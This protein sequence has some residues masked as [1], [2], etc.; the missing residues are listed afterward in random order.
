MIDL[1]GN[2]RRK[3]A[4]IE[5]ID[6]ALV[7]R[8]SYEPSRN[9]LG[10]SQLGE[11]CE[12]ALQYAYFHTPVEEDKEIDGQKQRIFDRGHM[13]EEYMLKIMRLA[14]FT[15][16]TKDLK[17]RTQFEF[18]LLEGRVKGHCDGVVVDGPSALNYPCL[19]ENKCLGDKYFKQLEKERLK[20]YSST[21]YGQV[22]IMAA[23]FELTENPSLFTA[24]NAND[25]N[26]YT[27]LVP[28]DGTE[29]QAI[30][31]KAVRIVKACD[32]GEQLSRITTDQSFWKCKWCSWYKRCWAT[33]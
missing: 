1:N 8:R 16:L 9:Y 4:I 7:K 29:A 2:T 24:L 31:D 33:V 21:Y 32:A 3:E 13:M 14:G 23:Y 30:S 11:E 25:M 10:A 15:V 20:K 5:I 28:F 12:R 26:I 18:S 17:T 19:W 22:Q 27:E 6:R